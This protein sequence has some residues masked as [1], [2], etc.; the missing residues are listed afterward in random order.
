MRQMTETTKIADP[1]R[2]YQ[3]ARLPIAAAYAPKKA[4][5]RKG[6]R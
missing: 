2:L 6:G 3:P 1:A 4:S 5:A